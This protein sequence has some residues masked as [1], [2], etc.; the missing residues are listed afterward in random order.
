MIEG[1]AFQYLILM[2]WRPE[3]LVV[4]DK[5]HIFWE[6]HKILRNLH[7]TFDF[8]YCSQS[9][10]GDFGRFCGPFRIY[11]LYHELDINI[12]LQ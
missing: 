7:L 10:D 5:V 8:V 6:G 1:G 2:I 9:K 12:T 4:F 11:E 3:G